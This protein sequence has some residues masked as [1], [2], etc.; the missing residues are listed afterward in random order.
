MQEINW[1]KR[2]ENA[3]AKLEAD[4]KI[5]LENREIFREFFDFQE[6][7]LKRMRGL[8]KLDNGNYRTLYGY[9]VKFR[10][11]NIWFENKAWK[12]LTKQD[13]QKVYDQ[14]EDGIITRKN[15]KPYE[16]LETSYY[17]KVMKSKPFELAG[18][19][20]LAREVIQF[21]T[22]RKKEVRFI[23]E[24]DFRRLLGCVGKPLHK[25]LFWLAWDIG[26]NINSLL[27]LKK[28]DF[29]KQSNP[30]TDEP[31]YRVNL[32]KEILK[33][34]RRAR[35]EITNYP[36]TVEL[37]DS[38]LESFQD[39]DDIFH[40][41]YRSAKKIIDRAVE[42]TNIRCIPNGEKTTWKDLRSSMACDLLKKG[43]TT[44]E[45][46]ARL[47]HK[48]SSDEID[49]YV[50]FLAIDRHTP[51]KKVEE[52]K[53]LQLKQSLEESKEKEKLQGMRIENLQKQMDRLQEILANEEM[54]KL[55]KSLPKEKL[56]NQ[57]NANIPG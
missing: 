39:G 40:F 22:H 5:C 53:L 41:G 55:V 21:K 12:E 11:I 49:K 28:S 23:T 52:F 3:R 57:R 34:S 47:G 26:E 56:I 1:E 6:V 15:G 18:K 7:R 2:Y 43:W 13:I 10:N 25:L 42:R 36:E 9:V 17:S 51:K 4:R 20:D 48:P 8:R 35:S 54:M 24:E 29:Y 32:R 31:E 37:L 33:R 46:N 45:V 50:N 14:L 19:D 44:D 38:L 27:R 16:N 30:Y